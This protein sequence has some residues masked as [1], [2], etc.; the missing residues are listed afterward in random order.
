MLAT[1]VPAE[2]RLGHR[3]GR[4]AGYVPGATPSWWC[5]SATKGPVAEVSP[6][7]EAANPGRGLP[8]AT[9]SAYLGSESE[10][11]ITVRTYWFAGFFTRPTGDL[12]SQLPP[13]NVHVEA[14]RPRE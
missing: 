10:L 3:F 5:P 9:L 1:S 11:V 2:S 8:G 12:D 7:S 4:S 14:C 6:L 13:Q